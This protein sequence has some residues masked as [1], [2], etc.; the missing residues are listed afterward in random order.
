MALPNIHIVPAGNHGWAVAVEG[1][2]GATTHYPTQE[3]AISAGT[4][5]AKQDK[6]ELLIHGEDGAIRARNSFG[7]DPRTVKG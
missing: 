2:D 7:H 3:E 4:E 6:V 5:K 1:T